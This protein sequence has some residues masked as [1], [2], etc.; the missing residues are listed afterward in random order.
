MSDALIRNLDRAIQTLIRRRQEQIDAIEAIE[1]TFLRLGLTLAPSPN[2]RAHRPR[3]GRPPGSGTAAPLKP[4]PAGRKGRR[5]KQGTFSKTGPASILAF[6]KAAGNAGRTSAEI[7]AHLNA[8]GRAG[9]AYVALGNLVKAGK[10]K[11]MNL[12]GERGSRY[13]VA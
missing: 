12:K 6:V 5:R 2:G 11:R 3:R 4:R 7:I 1:A 13:T 8:E 9:S 10:L